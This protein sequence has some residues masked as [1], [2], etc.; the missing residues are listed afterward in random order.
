MSRLNKRALYQLAY[1]SPDP[2]K[3]TSPE[4]AEVLSAGP[5]ALE[6][7][8]V[9]LKPLSVETA[10]ALPDGRLVGRLANSSTP[11]FSSSDA[12]TV[13]LRARQK[14]PER[15]SPRD[16]RRAEV[17]RKLGS[18]SLG[19]LTTAYLEQQVMIDEEVHTI[20]QRFY[21]LHAV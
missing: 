2:G 19:M 1:H 12:V 21:G 17:L 15:P 11:R 5:A 16:I 14:Q 20:Q 6:L 8:S 7:E 13:S 10:A 18:G 3:S 9:E 4:T